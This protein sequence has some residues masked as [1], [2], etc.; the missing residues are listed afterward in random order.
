MQ[1]GVVNNNSKFRVTPNRRFWEYDLELPVE[2][3]MDEYSNPNLRQN[4][5]ESLSPRQ[6]TMLYAVNQ[7]EAD[8]SKALPVAQMRKT[9]MEQ[10]DDLFN[11]YLVNRFNHAKLET[12]VSDIAKANLRDDLLEFCLV[13]NNK[14]DKKSLLF[15][16][17]NQNPDALKNIYHYD[18]IHKKGFA[19]FVLL[20]PARQQATTFADFISSYPISKILEQYDLNLGDGFESQLQD[21]FV[22]AGRIYLFIRRAS[23]EDVL[24]SSDQLLHGHK[25]EWT[26][27]DF[28]DNGKQ[29]NICAK[30]PQKSV[31]IANAL[32][33]EY[34][35]QPVSFTDAADVNFKKQVERFLRL[36]ASE[37]D[38]ELKLFEIRFRSPYFHNNTEIAISTC[39]YNS[40]A[41]DLKAMQGAAG[42]VLADITCVDSIKV[43]YQNKRI[44]LYFRC[45]DEACDHIR[46]CYSEHVLDKNAREIF[47][48]WMRDTYG[49]KILPKA[50]CCN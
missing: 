23:D 10:S 46:I 16:L 50:K 45:L 7:V 8:V 48:S 33:S 38:Q 41:E 1:M 21:T 44:T 35:N 17:F 20:N 28:A 25:P 15:A 29:V 2:R 36:S 47:K 26:I 22:H 34:F 5:L 3:L 9:L 32:I 14:Y 42:D 40:I 49:L 27:I 6:V 37:S 4:W 18:K 13:K 11:Y 31:F 19:A 12:A 39:P 30:C 43:L 24:L